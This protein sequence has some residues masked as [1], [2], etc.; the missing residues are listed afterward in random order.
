MCVLALP[1]CVLC[2]SDR[3][4]GDRIPSAAQLTG[5]LGVAALQELD[6]QARNRRFRL[7]FRLPPSEVLLE[8]HDASYQCVSEGR[9]PFRTRPH[10]LTLVERGNP[11]GRMATDTAPQAI[12]GRVYISLNYLSFAS[13]GTLPACPSFLFVKDCNV[14]LTGCARFVPRAQ[15]MRC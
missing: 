15:I 7:L 13:D 14:H 5:R 11:A 2:H 12:K 4:D 1:F 8:K 6:E 3:V 10:G 9:L